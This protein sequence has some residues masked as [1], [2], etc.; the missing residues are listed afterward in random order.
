MSSVS[1]KQAPLLVLCS[2]P[3]QSSRVRD[4]LDLYISL[5]SFDQ[6]A[7]LVIRDL[8]CGLLLP[9]QQQVLVK[10]MLASLNLLALFEPPPLWICQSSAARLGVSD[11]SSLSLAYQWQTPTQ[12]NQALADYSGE[13]WTW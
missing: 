3:Y 5:L 1:A 10:S 6:P 13:Q 7:Q 12:L 11:L 8:A 9:N 2:S 4:G